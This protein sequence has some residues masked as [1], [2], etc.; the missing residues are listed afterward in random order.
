MYVFDIEANGLLDDVTVVHCAVFIDPITRDTK[1]FTP[2]TIPEMFKFM[3]TQPVLCGHNVIGYDFPALLKVHGYKYKGKVVD[4]L[5]MSRLLCPNRTVPPKMVQDVRDKRKQGVPARLSGPHSIQS[6]GYTL[7]MGKVDHDEWDT[8]TPEM[9]NRCKMDTAIQVL[10]LQHL[11]TLMGALKFPKDVMDRTFSVFQILQDMEQYGWLFDVQKAKRSCSLLEHWMSRIER[12]IQP[13]L[14]RMSEAAE[15]T[16]N[17]AVNWVRK[18]FL[19]SGKYAAITTRTFPELEGKTAKEGVVGGPFSR[20]RFRTLDINS[21]NEMVQFLLQQGWVPREWNYQTDDNGR[22]VK[23]H[24]GNPI[25]SSPKLN[26]KDPFDGVQGVEGQLLAKWVQCRHRHSLITGLLELVRPDGRI[27]QRIT[28]IADTGRL[29]HGGIVNIP[30]GRSFFGHRI[31]SLFIAKKGYTLVGTDSVSCQDRCLANRANN[32]AFTDMLLNGDKSKGTDG[33]SLNMKAINKALL[34]FKVQITRDDA[35]N[36]GYGW[37]FGASDKKLGSMV[38]L[39]MEVGALI[40]AALAEVSSAQ[41]ALVDD[42]TRQWESTAKVRMSDYGRPQ[43]YGGTVQG[44]DGRPIRIEL[45]H[46][47]LVY[48]LQSDEAIIMQYALLLLKERLDKMGWVH[49]RE[50]GFVGNIH[51]EFQAEVRDDLAQQYAD[52]SARAIREASRRLNCV[53]LQEGDYSIGQS[54]AETH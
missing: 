29:T 25:R 28:G 10:L 46:T 41:A 24:K 40:R 16:V 12:V 48:I 52:L 21:R 1:V 5:V 33:H 26:Y 30:G 20:V 7:G 11:K 8:F 47:I 53:V 39:G 35:K 27:S 44:L 31:R 17:G 15:S 13:R 18:P 2:D 34:P 49:G 38:G 32:Q 54:W 45:P 4:T 6:W 37:K 36:H 22:V 19:T 50:Y 51:D 14:P 43:L 3:D 42:L 23:D 9:L